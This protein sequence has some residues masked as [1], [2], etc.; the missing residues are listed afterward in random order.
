M[1]PRRPS[2]RPAV[3]ALWLCTLLGDV[4]A[5]RSVQSQSALEASV[6]AGLATIRQRG[7][8][9]SATAPSFSGELTARS[10]RTAA[11]LTLTSTL[12]AVDRWSAQGDASLARFAGGLGSPWEFGG[13]ASALRYSGARPATQVGAYGRRHVDRL[14]WGA[15]A[16]ASVGRIGRRYW[17]TPLAAV[18][19]GAWTRR[20]PLQL[21][22]GLLTQ[23]ARLDSSPAY[24][25]GDFRGGAPASAPPPVPTA[26]VPPRP[27][28]PENVAARGFPIETLVATDATAL[29]AWRGPRLELTAS[30]IARHA[31]A[32]SSRPLGSAFAS[33]AW[34]ASP[35]LA[36]TGSA[37]TLADDPLRN[38]PES[39]FL[40]LGARWRP[41]SGAHARRAGRPLAAGA[42]VADTPDASAA[43]TAAY[44]VARDTSR[45]LRVRAP[46]ASRVE[47]RGD[48]TAWRPV[49]L[50]RR[51]AYWELA[52]A[53]D[54]GTQRL[55]LRVDDG[56]WAIPGNLPAVEDDFGTKVAL[57]VI[58]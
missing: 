13:T 52:L 11:R 31:P 30:V 48:A 37:G 36:L 15:W 16:G 42:P 38:V 40:T 56:P 27:T 19:G 50:E 5:P 55:L 22:L 18:E 12:A 6:D 35:T 26:G 53:L 58:P 43:G 33:V 25:F 17:N 54:P 9:T 44:A 21:S 23:R 14:A 24:D 57:I 34:W 20:G 29:A 46:G 2:G 7:D 45:V 39:R 41:A 51:G 3:R 28:A 32:Q 1:R 47:V 49:A 10:G 4:S 8:T